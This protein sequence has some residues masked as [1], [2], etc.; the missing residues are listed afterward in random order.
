MTETDRQTFKTKS[1]EKEKTVQVSFAFRAA[2]L[3]V[4]IMPDDSLAANFVE[5]NPVD[6]GVQ[7]V[8]EMSE[9]E[10]NTERYETE[11]RGQSVRPSVRHH[12]I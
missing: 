9:H 4:D 5:K 6:I 10:I 2:E 12:F 11:P 7:C 8:Q 1:Q 3:H